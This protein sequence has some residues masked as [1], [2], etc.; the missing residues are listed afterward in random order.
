[1]RRI[2]T[3][4]IVA[5]HGAAVLGVL[6]VPTWA[7]VSAV[8]SVTSGEFTAD[9]ADVGLARWP[10]LLANTLIVCGV[11]TAVA[12][13]LGIAAG[14]L[15]G[16]TNL[17]G[18]RWVL[19]AMS[20]VAC[21]PPVIVATFAFA[22]L[23]PWATPQ[24]P[25]VCGAMY[26]VTLAPLAALA[27]W[28]LLRGVDAEQEECAL[29]DASPRSV[30]FNITLRVASGGLCTIGLLV[31]LLVATDYSLADLLQVRT[32]SRE[33]YTQFALHRTAVGPLLTGGPAFV[34]I[35]LLLAAILAR[36]GR[37]LAPM[38]QG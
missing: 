8:R 31:A 32:F 13:G 16:R 10:L 26:G 2:A 17:T 18:R 27:A 35:A 20:F 38:L 21:L 34:V 36:W 12:L 4:V 6:S 11:A 3:R 30:F 19:G 22:T 15:M 24:S 7:I 28:A 1:M 14:G 29:L 33:V 25:W 37:A 23:P 5:M 9:G